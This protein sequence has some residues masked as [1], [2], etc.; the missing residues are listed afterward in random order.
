M[1]TAETDKAMVGLRPSASLRYCVTANAADGQPAIVAIFGAD[2]DARE[3]AH[4]VN[5]VH[6]GAFEN[7]ELFTLDSALPS[8]LIGFPGLFMD[9]RGLPPDH[10]APIPPDC[11]DSMDDGGV[12][13]DN[14]RAK[15]QE[16]NR[17]R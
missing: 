13:R 3:Y 12:A 17:N 5:K 7:V 4:D 2:V 6:G 16:D 10:I 14:A 11:D 1:T 8:K 9:W 15:E